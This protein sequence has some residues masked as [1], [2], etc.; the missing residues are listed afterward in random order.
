MF[1]CVAAAEVLHAEP[2]K[3]FILTR[4]MEHKTLDL[5]KARP[6]LF[7]IVAGGWSHSEQT[8]PDGPSFIYHSDSK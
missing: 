1:G 3:W 4:R 6:N 8:R 7:R 5:I 2:I